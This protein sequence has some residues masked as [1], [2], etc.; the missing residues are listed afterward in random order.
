VARSADGS[1][2]VDVPEDCDW[3]DVDDCVCDEDEELD[4]EDELEADW[5]VD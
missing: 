3:P 1:L 2:G 5:E 4:D